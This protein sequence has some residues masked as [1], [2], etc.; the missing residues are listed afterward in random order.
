MMVSASETAYMGWLQGAARCAKVKRNQCALQTDGLLRQSLVI[1]HL[2]SFLFFSVFLR[3]YINSRE[4]FL[5]LPTKPS[6]QEAACQRWRKIVSPINHT[7]SIR[8]K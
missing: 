1:F 4:A 2:Q 6:T 8:E 3:T 7:T 5:A